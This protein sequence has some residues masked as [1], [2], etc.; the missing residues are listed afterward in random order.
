MWWTNWV[1]PNEYTPEEIRDTSDVC[2]KAME[3]FKDRNTMYPCIEMI[4]ASSFLV[5]QNIFDILSLPSW[6]KS[7]VCLIGD[8]AHAVLPPSATS[9]TS[10]V[11]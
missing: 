3:L 1:I 4:N 6:H 9:L 8:A 2:E 7:R 11:S 10:G 5:K